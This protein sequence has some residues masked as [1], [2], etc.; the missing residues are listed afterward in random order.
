MSFKAKFNYTPPTKEI[1]AQGANKTNRSFDSAFF[2]QFPTFRPQKGGQHTIRLL[3]ATWDDHRG[4]LALYLNWHR[5]I[6]FNE[7]TYPCLAQRGERCPVCEEWKLNKGDKEVAKKFA[8]SLRAMYWVIDRD[9]EREGP[10]LFAPT[11]EFHN[12][13]NTRSRN[14]KTGEVVYKINDPD[15]GYD[16][17]FQ[18]TNT[19]YQKPDPGSITLLT[20]ATPITDNVELGEK[21]LDFTEK[22][23]LT[24]VIDWRDYDT[25]YKILHGVAVKEKEADEPITR[26]ERTAERSETIVVNS[27]PTQETKAPVAATMENLDLPNVNKQTGEVIDPDS[28]FDEDKLTPVSRRK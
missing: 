4:E 26:R 17:F 18:M 27:P 13:I 5:G 10:K 2:S 25:L 7:G 28:D 6:G 14:P 21:W 12:T 8:P 23:P 20:P 15:E 1:L 16:V 11:V 19:Q 22:H 24:S 9:K 3:P